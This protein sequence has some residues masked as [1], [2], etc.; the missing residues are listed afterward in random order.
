[1]YKNVFNF[2]QASNND[3]ACKLNKATFSS[4]LVRQLLSLYCPISGLVFDPFMG[5]GTTAIEAVQLGI[6]Y[7]GTELS[8]AQCDYAKERLEKEEDK[9]CVL[10]NLV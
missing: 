1:M 9:L 4:D 8:K 10:N 3:C 2:I 7:V 6:H 5:T